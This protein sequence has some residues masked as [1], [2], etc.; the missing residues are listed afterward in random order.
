M[1]T[2]AVTESPARLRGA[3][4]AR[5]LS[6]ADSPVIAGLHGLL[7]ALQA[8]GPEL[9]EEV[10]QRGEPL[11]AHHV[12]A[13][14]AVRA[15]RHQAGVPEHLQ[16]L[17]DGLLGD[18]ELL[19]DLVDRARPVAYQPQDVTPARLGEGLERGVA[20]APSVA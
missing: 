17:G 9:G 10:P 12:E 3:P 13:P 8:V 15:D 5:S 19:G 6:P 11:R 4:A 14:L 18:V 7:Q 2:D 16:V 1:C 20:H